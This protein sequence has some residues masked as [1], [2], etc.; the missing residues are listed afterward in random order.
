MLAYKSRHLHRFHYST[1]TLNYCILF[2]GV[3]T[4]L[5]S[6][7]HASVRMASTI[8]QYSMSPIEAIQVLVR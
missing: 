8:L 6:H 2:F 4:G 1:F 7:V 3:N 5:G